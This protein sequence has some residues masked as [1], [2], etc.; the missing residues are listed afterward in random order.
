M[1]IIEISL[2]VFL[3]LLLESVCCAQIIL[4]SDSIVFSGVVVNV[5]TNENL[6][7]VHCRYGKSQGI[8]SDT[9]GAFRLV[10]QR[11]DSV[12]FSYV[13]FKP[14]VIVI[15]DTLYESEYLLG[16]FMTPDTLLL[17]E[18]LIIGKR[19]ESWRRD[20]IALQNNMSGILSKALTPVAEMDADMNQRMMLNE[21]ARAVEMKGHVDVGFG[22][23]TQSIDAYR[24]LR[25][26]ER[27]NKK[28]SWLN[29]EEIDL[30]KKIY[31]SEKN[32]KA[33]N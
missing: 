25:L 21:Y 7:N 29:P 24:L 6:P 19:R 15:P 11:G 10:T 12:V 23:G 13:G 33:N 22:V 31:Y 16:V 18:V 4:K 20:R 5:Q 28:K 17:P 14:C 9:E 26:R 1:R 8:L 30:L 27:L 3:C 2:V 32:R